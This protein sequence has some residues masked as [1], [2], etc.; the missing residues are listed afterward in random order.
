MTIG[1][2]VFLVI[3]GILVTLLVYAIVG[4]FV[5]HYLV[6]RAFGRFSVG[7]LRRRKPPR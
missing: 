3:I 6:V 7:L 4:T 5:A 2:I 1:D